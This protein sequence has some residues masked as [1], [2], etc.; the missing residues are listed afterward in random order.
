MDVGGVDTEFLQEQLLFRKKEA[1][2]GEKQRRLGPQT[3]VRGTEG[4]RR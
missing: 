4:D 1:G 3:G 2:A